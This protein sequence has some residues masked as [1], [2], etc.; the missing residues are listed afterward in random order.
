M[1][2]LD[3][4]TNDYLLEID[5]TIET[6][7]Y[8]KRFKFVL[9]PQWVQD[10]VT[11]ANKNPRDMID[12]NSLSNILSRS[13]VESYYLLNQFATVALSDFTFSEII[14]S[15][16][17]SDDTSVF[18]WGSEG[19]TN[20]DF[21]PSIDVK[22]GLKQFLYTY[23]GNIDLVT[24]SPDSYYISIT[25]LYNDVMAIRIH[26]ADATENVIEKQVQALKDWI[27]IAGKYVSFKSITTSGILKDYLSLLKKQLSASNPAELTP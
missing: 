6:D 7:D 2:V 26:R 21:L 15:C 18:K 20:P 13:D 5:E 9:L 8:K 3:S 11:K 17:S 27:G 22:P 24:D 19:L 12:L 25:P 1:P 10:A 14:F 16:F 4:Y 23:F